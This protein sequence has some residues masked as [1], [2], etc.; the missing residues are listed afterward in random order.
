MSHRNM[1]LAIAIALAAALNAAPAEPEK[2][3]AWSNR[4]IDMS[5]RWGVEILGIRTTAAGYML[6]FRYRVTD[7]EKAAPIFKRRNKPVLIDRASKQKFFVASSPTVGPMRSS[8]VPQ[9]GRTYFMLFGNP[10]GYIR[11]GGRVSIEVGPFRI[12]EL[13]VQ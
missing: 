5:E 3:V 7:V 8:D 9:A 2:S 12:D 1:V 11:P 6:D 13:T 4:T 10:G